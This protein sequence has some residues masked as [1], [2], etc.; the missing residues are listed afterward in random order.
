MRAKERKRAHLCQSAYAFIISYNWISKARTKVAPYCSWD[1]ALF[2][3]TN[4]HPDRWW[5][6]SLHFIVCQPC[7]DYF[8]RSFISLAETLCFC[9]C[10]SVPEFRQQTRDVIQ[11]HFEG[12]FFIRLALSLVWLALDKFI[13]PIMLQL[14]FCLS[15]RCVALWIRPLFN[16]WLCTLIIVFVERILRGWKLCFRYTKRTFHFER[17]SRRQSVNEKQE[18]QRLVEGIASHISQSVN[19]IDKT[20]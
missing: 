19:S 13:C 10:E 7:H 5:C 15:A 11:L 14:I 3:N 18:K 16:F 20:G 6:I 1:C 2:Y 17:I 8:A 4:A 12:A 9:I